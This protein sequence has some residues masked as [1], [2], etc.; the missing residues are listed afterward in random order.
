MPAR[1][2][3]KFSIAVNGHTIPGDNSAKTAHDKAAKWMIVSHHR[4]LA[5]MPPAMTNT[6]NARCTVIVTSVNARYII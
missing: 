5:T 3:K 6:M 2:A 4:R 1:P